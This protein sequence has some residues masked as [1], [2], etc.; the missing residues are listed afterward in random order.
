MLNGHVLN[1][2]GIAR[3]T[4]FAAHP[5]CGRDGVRGDGNII[6]GGAG[7]DLIEGRGGDDILDGDRWLNVQLT[8]PNPAGGAA[9]RVNS[10]QQLKTAVFAGQINPGSISYIR[11]IIATGSTVADI[12]VAV[13]S[14]PRANYSVVAGPGRVTVTDNVGTDGVD[15]LFNIE[16]L[17]FT[18]VTINSPVTSA[19]TIVP[20]VLNNQTLA[21]A[22]ATLAAAGFGVA[23]ASANSATVPAGIVMSQTPAAGTVATS[24]STVG[25]VVSL[26]P[27]Q[28]Q[29]PNVVGS[30]LGAATTQLQGL[31]FQVTSTTVANAAP[32]GQVL[33]QT[34]TALTTANQGSTV[35]LTVSAGPAGLGLVAAFGF[36][37]TTGTA[38]I[39]SSA[40]PRNGTFGAAGA[41]PARVTTGKFGRAVRFDG[42]DNISVIDGAAGTKLDLTTGMTVEAWVNPSSM[43]GWESVVYKERGAAGTGLLSYALYARDGAPT[44]G[45]TIGPAGYIRIGLT[46]QPIRRAPAVALPLNVWSHI[47][48][49]Y[50]G[51]RYQLYVNGVMV[52]DRAQT[53]TMAVGNQ[54]LRIGNSNAQIS[55]RLQR[56]DRRS[57]DLQPRALGGRDRDQHELADRAVTRTLPAPAFCRGRPFSNRQ[58]GSRPGTARARS[59]SCGRRASGSDR[60]VPNHAHTTRDDQT[61]VFRPRASGSRERRRRPGCQRHRAESEPGDRAVHEAT[62]DSAA[63]PAT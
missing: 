36:E 55:R 7:S 29:V 4:G 46:D 33:S 26:G 38:V 9:L 14:G 18:D 17:Q 39:D 12:D 30:T 19:G 11:E 6:L 41:A 40:S 59:H 10:L 53:G 51:V 23:S 56:D 3:I 52:A 27:V 35:A 62:Q 37:E 34:P 21:Q 58:S 5:A 31:G 44:A 54:P 28:V 57:P 25:I 42:G 32:A 47:A 1:A 16:R 43:S 49:T 24:G 50:N 2:A 22:T 61:R 60:G 8:A 63:A 45:G 48:A 15:T 13:F 20:N